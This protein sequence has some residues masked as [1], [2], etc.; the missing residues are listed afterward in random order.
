MNEASQW[1]LKIARKVTPIIAAHPK[2]QA[3]MLGGSSSRGY[4]DRYSDIEIGV[5]WSAPPTDEER[6]A[7]IEPAG[8]VFWELDPYDQE[9]QTWME[10]WGLHGLKMDMRNLTVEG[11]ETILADVIDHY[12]ITPFKQ[13]TI[14]AVQYAIPLYNESLFGQWKT[15]LAHYPDELGRRMVEEHLLLDSWCWWVEMLIWRADW[16]MVYQS[17]SE[18][19]FELLS[20]LMGL[21]RM[22]HPGFK[23]MNRSIDEMHIAPIDLAARITSVFRLDPPVALQEMRKLVLDVYGLVEQYMTAVDVQQARRLFLRQR[24]QFEQPPG[25]IL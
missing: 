20:L 5:F 22:Y 21:N 17:F 25:G 3:V 9:N 18:A 15:K 23:W 6:M 13:A 24:A 19:I 11:M 4:A 1:R 12:D 8:G 14:S 10:E 2:V 16:P 7:P